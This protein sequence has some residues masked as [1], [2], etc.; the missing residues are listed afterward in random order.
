MA[1]VVIRVDITL[2]SVFTKTTM[3]GAP[4]GAAAT[5][6]STASVV[7]A[8]AENCRRFWVDQFQGLVP[9]PNEI[10][11]ISTQTVT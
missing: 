4:G 3:P 10:T 5:L 2:T 7:D 8:Y 9:N 11:T 1:T 6:A